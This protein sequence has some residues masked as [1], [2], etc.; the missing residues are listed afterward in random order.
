[1]RARS[2][3]LIGFAVF[4][5]LGVAASSGWAAPTHELTEKDNGKTVTIKVGEKLAVNLQNPGDGGYSVVSLVYDFDVLKV[6]SSEKLPPAPPPKIGDW[7][8]LVFTWKAEGTGESDL[9][10]QFS[11]VFEKDKPPL[12]SFKV[13]VKVIK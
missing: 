10:V 12:D 8:R 3:L 1:M 11:R 5:C 4:L 9:K 2:G 6:V 13:T 7:G